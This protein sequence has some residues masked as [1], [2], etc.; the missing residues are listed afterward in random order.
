MKYLIHICLLFISLS[1]IGQDST[2]FCNPRLEGMAR[3][4][5]L[6][7]LYERTLGANI[8]STSKDTAFSNSQATI[9]NINRLDIDLKFPIW[10]KPG[11]KAALGFR[12]FYEEYNFKNPEQLTYPL[13]KNIQDKHLKSLGTNLSVLKPLNSIN[14]LLF[15]AAFEL[16][17]DYTKGSTALSNP[18][19]LKYNVA[20]VY[21]WKPCPTKTW[22][23]GL[24]YSYTFGRRAVLPV[25]IYNNTFTKKWGL[26]AIVPIDVKMRRN[27][28][29]KTL[30]YVGY[31]IQGTPYHIVLDQPPVTNY[32]DLELRRS[33]LRLMAEFN[34]E[35]HDWLWFGI[36]AGI[37]QP[38][39][40]NFYKSPATFNNKVVHNIINS[41]GFFNVSIFVVPPR[42]LDN[43]LLNAKD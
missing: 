16:N 43:R 33:T 31:D 36:A 7:V 21:G 35:I 10:N 19:F 42:T 1:T 15:R 23:L 32:K 17:G 2:K 37:R 28:S 6:T 5:G 38:I 14:Y 9:Q 13:Y 40:F 3:S 25:F 27:F 4:K 26:E 20:A 11:L 8:S 41:T 22:G 12:Y 39:S 34:R 24:Y 30:L 18:S 29:E